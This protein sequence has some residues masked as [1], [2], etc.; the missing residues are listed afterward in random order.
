MTALPSLPCYARGL[1]AMPPGP[2]RARFAQLLD[3]QREYS[4]DRLIAAANVFDILP[5]AAMPR[6]V[7]LPPEVHAAKEQAHSIFSRL[8]QAWS[9]T[10]CF[11]LSAASARAASST[12]SATGRGQSWKR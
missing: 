2:T 5:A 6:D 8:P 10:R 11:R 7:E 12:R 4:I 9:A 1:S 3:H